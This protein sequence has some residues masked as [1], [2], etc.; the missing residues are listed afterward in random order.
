ML[1][2]YA[3]LFA[4]LRYL[5]AWTVADKEPFLLTTFLLTF[6]SSLLLLLPPSFLPL[7]LTLTLTPL[8]PVTLLCTVTPLLCPV[9]LTCPVTPLCPQMRELPTR[10]G[11]GSG[12]AP[13]M[14]PAMGLGP[15]AAT[16]CPSAFRVSS[17]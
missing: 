1:I 3:I 9:T 2:D 5:S 13:W 11:F 15:V 17:F 14:G 4:G 7:T 12:L 16:K 6:P 8:R 10:E